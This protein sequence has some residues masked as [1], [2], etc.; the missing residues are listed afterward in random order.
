MILADGESL[1]AS[2]DTHRGLDVSVSV[3]QLIKIVKE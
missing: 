3:K 2:K 1:L